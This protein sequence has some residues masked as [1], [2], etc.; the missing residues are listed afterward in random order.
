M[1]PLSISNHFFI[2]SDIPKLKTEK[3]MKDFRE[4]LTKSDVIFYFNHLPSNKNSVLVY[5]RHS[6]GMSI[7]LNQHNT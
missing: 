5:A 2:L 6:E 7:L 4:K 1:R 3:D